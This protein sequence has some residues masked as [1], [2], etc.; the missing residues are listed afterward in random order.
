MKDLFRNRFG[1]NIVFFADGDG[2]GGGE[3]AP[4]WHGDYPYLVENKEASRAFAK[5][6]EPN[7]AFKGAHEAMKKVGKPYLMPEDHSKLTEDQKNEIRA[8][9]AKMNGVPDTADGYVINVSPDTK[10]A[11]DAQAI[12]DFKI[13]AKSKNLPPDVAQDLVNFQIAFADRIAEQGNQAK[14]EMTKENF[15]NFSKKLGGDANTLM[16]MEQVKNYLQSKCKDDKGAP[17]P[18]KWES[19]L[20]RMFYED[21]ITEEV[22]FNALLEPARQFSTGGAPAGQPAAAAAEGAL[23]YKEMDK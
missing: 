23:A 20:A 18:K 11:V 12:A 7:D 9:V 6:K 8:N 10:T 5:Y 13:F 2:G 19:F 14:I 16:A 22:L 1:R 15:R 3:T 17:D 21:K 4:E